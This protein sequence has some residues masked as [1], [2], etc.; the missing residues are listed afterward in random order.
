MFSDVTYYGTCVITGLTV[1]SH[2]VSDTVF[3]ETLSTCN[4]KTAVKPPCGTA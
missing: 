4:W 3:D 1:C 2:L